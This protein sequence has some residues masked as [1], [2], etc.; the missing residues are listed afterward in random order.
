MKKFQRTKENS[1]QIGMANEMNT[2]QELWNPLCAEFNM[3]LPSRRSGD[4]E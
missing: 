2:K 3:N 1:E 4:T